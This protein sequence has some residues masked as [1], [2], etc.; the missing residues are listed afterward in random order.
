MRVLLSLWIFALLYP[1]GVKLKFGDK[2]GRGAPNFSF[3]TTEGKIR[4]VMDFRGRWLLLQFGGSWCTPSEATAEY[5]SR[6]RR[7]LE[8]RPFEF[9]EI[10]DDP[11]LIDVELFSFTDFSGLRAVTEQKSIPKFYRVGS[12]P[13]WYL[14][15]PDGVVQAAGAFDSASGLQKIF[16]KNLAGAAG[17]EGILLEPSIREAAREEAVALP[18]SESKN[19]EKQAEAWEAEL[20]IDPNDPRAICGKARTIA[21][22]EGYP[23]ANQFLREKMKTM[24][25]VPPQMKIFAI[26]YGLSDSAMLSAVQNLAALAEEFPLSDYLRAWNLVWTKPPESLTFEEARIV[27]G[28]VQ[29]R[30]NTELKQYLAIYLAGRG[31]AEGA[32]RLFDGKNE[33]VAWNRLEEAGFLHRRGESAAALELIG[34]AKGTYTAATAN[35]AQAWQEM[36]R[37]AM[38]EDWSQVEAFAVRYEEVR[39]KKIQGLLFRWLAARRMNQME[40]ATALREKVEAFIVG[41]PRYEVTR[42]LLEKDPVRDDFLKIGDEHVRFDSALACVLQS[43]SEGDFDRARKIGR[44]AIFAFRPPFWCYAILREVGRSA[45]DDG[46]KTSPSGKE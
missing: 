11:S 37:F 7:A 1:V 26:D 35:P 15:N 24:E 2:I 30:G 14:I 43:E 46:S 33:S 45:P 25:T 3:F 13:A 17:F 4:R 42:P 23:K 31:K 20:A 39:P 22:L 32:T 10:Y 29:Q 18:V 8:G 36:L 6:I 38:V 21:W 5:F 12:I 41:S 40:K 9:V 27:A 28:A 19:R 16:E 34:P 44:A